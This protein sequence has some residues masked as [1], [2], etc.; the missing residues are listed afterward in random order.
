M[1]SARGTFARTLAVIAL[2]LGA[3]LYLVGLDALPLQ[4]GNEAMY[5]YP[6]I[7]MLKSGDLLVPRYLHAPFLDKPPLTFWILAATYRVLG[8]SVFAARLPGVLAALATVAA[9]AFWVR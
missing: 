5:A 4:C 2:V 9:I 8:I 1:N 7:E 6:P 3:A